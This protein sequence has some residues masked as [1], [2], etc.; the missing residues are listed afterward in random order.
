MTQVLAATVY[1]MRAAGTRLRIAPALKALTE[2]AI[3]SRLRTFIRDDGLDQWL[4]GGLARV[5]PAAQGLGS[6][7]RGLREA[8]NCDALLLQREALPLNNL[9]LE[10]LV[11]R[12]GRPI[13][14]DTAGVDRRQNARGPI[15]GGVVSNEN[16]ARQ[17][18]RGC[19]HD[20]RKMTEGR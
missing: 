11:A 2:M 6:A 14:W 4:Q 7:S 5:S 19:V 12:R 16:G 13:I 9:S 20:A 17:G 15:G 1:P 3:S 10:R 18:I 8:M